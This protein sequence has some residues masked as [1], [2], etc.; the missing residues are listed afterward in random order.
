MSNIKKIL[1]IHHCGQVGGAGVSLLHIIKSLDKKIYDIHVICPDEPNNMINLLS[2]EE[3]KIITIKKSIKIF[4]HY[5]GGIENT[6]SIKSIKNIIGILLNKRDL[7]EYIKKINPDIVIVNSMTLCW[8]GKI[9]KSL[10]KKAICFHRETYQ[11][12]KFNLSTKYIKYCLNKW[13]DTVI[14]ISKYDHDNTPK[15]KGKKYVVYDKVEVDKYLKYN[16]KK[17]R[18]IL[19]FSNNFKYI[20]YLGGFDKLKGAHIIIKSLKYL[21]KDNIKLVFIGDNNLNKNID[22]Y[23]KKILKNVIKYNLND[24]VIF[25]SKTN[26]PEVFYKACDLVVFPSTKPHQARPIYEAGISKIPIIITDFEET[27]EFACEG[28]TAI[29]F[30]KNN[31]KQLSKKIEMVLENKINLELLINN[32]YQNSIK[33]H[34]INDLKILNEI[35]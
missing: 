12:G 7:K 14:F 30:K 6:F 5:N 19:G 18:E 28:K 27:S 8:C 33:N 31:V 13:F 1:I 20:L 3:C 22:I 16:K 17:S 29:T 35:L 11:K 24:K 21:K 34:N 10:N 32:N 15:K 26:N 4:A 9:I 25:M 2:K 23:K